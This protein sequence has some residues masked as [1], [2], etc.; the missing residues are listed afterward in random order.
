MHNNTLKIS[1]YDF[2]HSSSPSTRPF[3][4][5]SS[6]VVF[7]VKQACVHFCFPFGIWCIEGHADGSLCLLTK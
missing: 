3:L 2:W 7:L 5:A 4:H 1:P 6:K